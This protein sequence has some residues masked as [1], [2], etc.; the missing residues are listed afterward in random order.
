MLLQT[1]LDERCHEVC[2]ATNIDNRRHES[3]LARGTRDGNT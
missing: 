3:K 1:A 2:A